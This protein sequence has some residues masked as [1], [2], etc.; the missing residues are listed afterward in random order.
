M[1]EGKRTKEGEGQRKGRDKGRGG[2]KEGR[3][4]ECSDTQLAYYTARK[5]NNTHTPTSHEKYTAVVP[6]FSMF[7]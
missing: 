4:I 7:K 1:K 6:Q 5:G 3:E 2:M